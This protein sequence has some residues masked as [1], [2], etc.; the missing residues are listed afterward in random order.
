MLRK[1][2]KEK[3]KRERVEVIFMNI[4][5]GNTETQLESNTLDI[6]LLFY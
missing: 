1:I 3:C 6:I 2:E 5:W 4:L